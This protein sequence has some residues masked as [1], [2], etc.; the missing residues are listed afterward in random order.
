MQVS[1]PNPF[2]AR[3]FIAYALP[4]LLFA[5]CATLGLR[6]TARL[7]VEEPY[8]NLEDGDIGVP[9]EHTT[10]YDD[11]EFRVLLALDIINQ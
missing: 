5:A 2:P 8:S 3:V 7:R 1:V 6:Y 11:K 10:V 9:E 4:A